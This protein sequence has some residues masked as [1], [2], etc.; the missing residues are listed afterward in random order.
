MDLAM[1]ATIFCTV[2]LT[3]FVVLASLLVLRFANPIL[4]KQKI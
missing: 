2:L 3:R 1:S 4:E